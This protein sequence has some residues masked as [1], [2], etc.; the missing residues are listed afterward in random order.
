M[1]YN[2]GHLSSPRVAMKSRPPPDRGRIEAIN[3]MED[4]IV[5][6]SVG[7]RSLTMGKDGLQ[8]SEGSD[9]RNLL[10]E[11]G[12]LTGNS[13]FSAAVSALF[14]LGIANVKA[15]ARYVQGKTVSSATLV[16]PRVSSLGA[17]QYLSR[18]WPEI[19]KTWIWH[20]FCFL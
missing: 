16:T 2:G 13:G 17:E 12:R 8:V 7:G 10:D 4:I 9:N 3:P 18:A 15:G 6:D 5:E 11:G 20:D 19:R 14:P 1:D